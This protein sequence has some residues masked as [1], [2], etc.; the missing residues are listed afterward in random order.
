M[1]TRVGYCW[2][3]TGTPMKAILNRQEVISVWFGFAFPWWLVI[4]STFSRTCWLFGC[5]WEKL[6]L[7]HSPFFLSHAHSMWASWARDRTHITSVTWAIS[8]ARCATGELPS[9]HLKNLIFFLELYEFFIILASN[10]TSDTWFAYVSHAVGCP[11]ILFLWQSRC[12]EVSFHLICW[13]FFLF[14]FML[15][16]SYLKNHCWD[17]CQRPAFLSQLM[18]KSVIH[19]KLI[20]SQVNFLSGVR[21]GSY[22]IF[23]HVVILLSQY[24]MFSCLYFCFCFD[25]Y[26]IYFLPAPTAHRSSWAQDQTRATATTRAIAVTMPGP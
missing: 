15:L 12:F 17:Q 22:F 25:Y 23:L 4:L 5:C 19:F 7:V 2:A 9:A 10:P 14:L 8:L 13:F 21:Y 24:R 20:F 18:F 16:V 26:G 1:D 3:T 11:F 6:C